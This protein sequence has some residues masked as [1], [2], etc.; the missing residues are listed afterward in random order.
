METLT[1]GALSSN[2]LSAMA[3]IRVRVLDDG[4]CRHPPDPGLQD[5][6]LS[7][8]TAVV[9]NLLLHLVHFPH[10]GRRLIIEAMQM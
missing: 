4:F 10:A 5:W 2:K 8:V 6:R 9:Q 3:D 1:Y 7:S